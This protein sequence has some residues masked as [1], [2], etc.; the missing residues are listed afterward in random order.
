VG[1]AVEDADEAEEPAD[2]ELGVDAEAAEDDDEEEMEIEM[3]TK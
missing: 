3:L 2:D 1:I